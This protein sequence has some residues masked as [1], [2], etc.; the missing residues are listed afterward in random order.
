M[1]CVVVCC[2]VCVVCYVLHVVKHALFGVCSGCLMFAA[3]LLVS[4][5]V[6]CWIVVYGVLFVN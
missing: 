2:L 5:V 6:W 3:L 1:L 4:V